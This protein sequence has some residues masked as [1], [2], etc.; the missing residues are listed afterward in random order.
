MSAPVVRGRGELRSYQRIFVNKIKRLPSLILALPMGSGKTATIL[1]AVLDLLNDEAV[2][3]VLIIAPRLVASATWPDE[4]EDWEHTRLL[5]WTLIRVE[6]DDP[7]VVAARRDAT[8]P[9][10]A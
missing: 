5:T 2:R 8:R 6:D 7:E 10:A 3:K 1:T 9:P 4:I